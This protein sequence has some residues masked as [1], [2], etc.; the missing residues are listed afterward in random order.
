V[1]VTTST[2]RKRARIA[3]LAENAGVKAKFAQQLF[4]EGADADDADLDSAAPENRSEPGRPSKPALVS[5]RDLK[6]RSLA[7]QAGRAVL[8]HALAHIE[9]NAI[10]LALDAVWR[11]PAMPDDFALDWAQVAMEEARHFELLCQHLATLGQV[12]GDFPA[13]NG[14]WEMAE[15]TKDDVLARLGL[16]P[17]TLEAR[18]LDVSPAI[19]D[20]LKQAGDHRGAQ[21]LDII[22]SDEIR[23]VAIGNQWFRFCCTKRDLDP[24]ATYKEL[25]V[26]YRAPAP[27]GPFNIE[28]RLLAGFEPA[29]I[30]ALEH[31]A[32]AHKFQ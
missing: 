24:V 6:Q 25:A 7:T 29:E 11:Y 19:R 9:F 1:N 22:L 26:R 3:L 16:V 14:L 15:K 20:K 4:Q 13:H 18:G 21:I 8:F 31:A 5:P 28:A 23:H 27:R 30:A 17:R 10:N 32:S 12:Y 2:L